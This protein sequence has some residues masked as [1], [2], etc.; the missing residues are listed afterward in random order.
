MQTDNNVIQFKARPPKPALKPWVGPVQAER[1]RCLAV[2]LDPASQGHWGSFARILLCETPLS[3]ED[4]VDRLKS[5]RANV[6]AEI[7]ADLVSGL[8]NTTGTTT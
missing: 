5:L 8:L 2:C 1:N 4:I 6:A 7:Q 3:A